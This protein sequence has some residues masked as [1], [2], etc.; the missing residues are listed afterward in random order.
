MDS[1]QFRDPS[2][3]G[4]A[5]FLAVLRTMEG[6]V[7]A[8]DLSGQVLFMNP[9]AEELTG[10]SERDSVGRPM[11]IFQFRSQSND[12]TI[13]SALQRDPDSVHGEY[14]LLCADGVPVGVDLRSTTVK[15][16]DGSVLGS[17][18]VFG[19]SK[20]RR[21]LHNSEARLRGIIDS[22]MDAIITVDE[23]QVVRL[24]NRAAEKI[25]GCDAENAIGKPLDQ[26]IPRRYREMHRFDVQRFGETGVTARS[27]RSPGQLWA[28]R[29]TG[30]EF[31][32][33]ATISQLH[34]QGERLFT[35]ILRDVTDKK[36][37]EQALLNSEKLAATGRL[38]ATIAHE[39]NNPL[40]ATVNLLFLARTNRDRA[41]E[42]LQSAERELERVSAITKQ[43]LGFYRDSSVPGQIAIH[44]LL[45]E[46]IGA[47]TSQIRNRAIV[48]SRDFRRNLIVRGA[49]GEL[50]QIFSNLLINAIEA[51]PRGGRI[52]LTID[53]APN[54]SASVSIQDDGPGIQSADLQ[55]IFDPFF[56]TKKTIG[57]G[58]GLWVVKE[59]V[60]RNGGDVRVQTSASPHKHGTCFEVLLPLDTHFAELEPD[61]TASR[62]EYRRRLSR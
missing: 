18:F 9:M 2:T 25:F 12:E 39:I 58:L 30:E 13:E 28:L 47:Y 24:F 52:A 1:N 43:T 32:I 59:L 54:H 50:R 4:P 41:D 8:F 61:S 17:I 40:E 49:R 21:K 33:E 7:I 15:A 14:V 46:V 38:A 5:W 35:V 20:A 19:D 34:L 23:K 60:V 57:T 3:L 29:V 55:R 16:A 27:M 37:A 45:N 62:Y 48:I 44:D 53:S 31:P 56:T 10:Y 11:R 6:C 22:A 51:S 26:F 42:F 36:R